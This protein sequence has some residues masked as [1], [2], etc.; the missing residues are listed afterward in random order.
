LSCSSRLTPAFTAVFQPTVID[1]SIVGASGV[2]GWL[3]DNHC[4]TPE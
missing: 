3:G 4:C 2:A 1:M